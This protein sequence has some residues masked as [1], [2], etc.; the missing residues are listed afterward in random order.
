MNTIHSTF[1]NS[2]ILHTVVGGAEPVPDNSIPLTVLVLNRG[3][4]YDR[5]GFFSNLLQL[6]FYSI[7]SVEQSSQS[8]EVENLTQTF[9]TVKFV[10]STDSLKAGEMIWLGMSETLNDKVLV[11]WSDMKI[12]K[13]S[14]SSRLLEKL[15]VSKDVV[16]SPLLMNYRLE[17]LPVI[18]EPL[19]EKQNFSV[20]P[21][22]C[23]RDGSISLYPWDFVGVYDR[24][25]FLELD[26][27]DLELN[28]PYWQLLDFGFKVWMKSHRITVS[29]IF[30]INYENEI[31]IE[32]IN[33]NTDYSCFY[34][35]NL[36]PVMKKN[37]QGLTL[38]I[39]KMWSF[40]RKSGFGLAKGFKIF[41]AIRKTINSQHK[42][43]SYSGSEII[44]AWETFER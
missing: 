4:K 16:V 36:A 39:K 27:F 5:V 12:S 37:K 28:D 44:D 10:I 31:P 30:R 41:F 15:L 32:E 18:R 14:I 29:S 21:V 8:Y 43:F 9:P 1:K 40:A 25:L 7:I 17:A 42:S 20:T 19:L 13:N 26:G 23:V 35:K 38:S 2:Q 33:K 22:M 6:G 11:I 34:L 3:G 24:S